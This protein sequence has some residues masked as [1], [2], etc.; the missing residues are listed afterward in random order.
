MIPMVGELLQELEIRYQGGT[1]ATNPETQQFSK[2]LFHPKFERLIHGVDHFARHLS[3]NGL[4]AYA[5]ASF[6][7]GFG[8]HSSLLWEH[9]E[10]LESLGDN[11]NTIL[12][13]FGV[14]CTHGDEFDTLGL[15]RY[16]STR[17]WVQNQ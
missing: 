14:V 15:G 2:S 12:K 13:L 11:I 1:E 4:I 10:R 8:G 9:G 7:G 17:L 3:R 16:R 6:I 5:E